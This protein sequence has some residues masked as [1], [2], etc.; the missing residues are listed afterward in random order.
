MA[1]VDQAPSR[2]SAPLYSCSVFT[3]EAILLS[4]FGIPNFHVRKTLCWP[5]YKGTSN[6]QFTFNKLPSWFIILFWIYFTWESERNSVSSLSGCSWCGFHTQIAWIRILAFTFISCVTL[7]KFLICLFLNLLIYVTEDSSTYNLEIFGEN[8]L[9]YIKCLG[10]PS[11]VDWKSFSC[12]NY[13]PWFIHKDTGSRIR[14]IRFVLQHKLESRLP[15]EISITSE[16]QMIPPL[17]QKVK[18]N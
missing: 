1:T 3:R 2:Y 12:S 14:L 6:S 11:L 17:W 13:Y 18:R 15:G 9:T 5:T 8:E 7:G 4:E 10:I 16:M